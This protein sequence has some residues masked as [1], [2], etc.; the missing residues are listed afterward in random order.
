MIKDEMIKKHDDLLKE[1]W[2]ELKELYRCL[3]WDP[4]SP[5]YGETQQRATNKMRAMLDA[6]LIKIE[7]AL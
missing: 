5:M 3:A 6:V 1:I 2:V 4:T 7:D